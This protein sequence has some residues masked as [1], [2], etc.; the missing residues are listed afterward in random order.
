MPPNQDQSLP[1][2]FEAAAA[3]A[4]EYEGKAVQRQ[5]ADPATRINKLAAMRTQSPKRRYFQKT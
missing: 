1:V 2:A 3:A 4:R 5:A